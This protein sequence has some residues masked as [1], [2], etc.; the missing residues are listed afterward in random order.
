MVLSGGFKSSGFALVEGPEAE[1][2]PGVALSD[3]SFW[4]S[5]FFPFTLN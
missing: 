5:F 4:A 1:D 3:S 2:D